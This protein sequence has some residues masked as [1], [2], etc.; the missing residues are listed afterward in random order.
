MGDTYYIYFPAGPINWVITAKDIQGPWS[1]PIDL[2]IDCINLGLV[3]T[4][5]GKHYLFTNMGHV[6]PL[7]DDGL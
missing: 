2:K 4:P 1:D 5:D 7:S 3:V 6:T